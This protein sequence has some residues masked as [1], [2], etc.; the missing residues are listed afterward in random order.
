MKKTSI[1][2]SALAMA[3]LLVT[4][5]GKDSEEATTMRFLRADGETWISDDEQKS[6]DVIEGLSLY[7][8]YGVGTSAHANAWLTLDEATLA[9]MDYSSEIEIEKSDDGKHLEVDVKSGKM[10][11]NVS[12]PLEDDESLDIETSTMTVG[13]RGT[14]GW[15]ESYDDYS[16]VALLEGEVT[17]MSKS[18][19]DSVILGEGYMA[20]LFN[21][22]GFEVEQF[23][24]KD[25]PEFVMDEE[26]ALYMLETLGMN[27]DASADDT[28]TNGN[29]PDSELPYDPKAGLELPEIPD[30]G[31]EREV[32]EVADNDALQAL[33]SGGRDLSNTAIRLGDGE[34]AFDNGL[35]IGAYENLSIIGTGKTR[36]VVNNGGATVLDSYGAKNLLLY[37]LVLGHDISP[38]DECSMG[39]LSFFG[40]ENVSVVGCD[41]YGCG[42]VGI[43]ASSDVT[44]TDSVIRECSYSAVETYSDCTV[45]FIN[46]VIQD[47]DGSYLF[48]GAEGTKFIFDDCIIQGNHSTA[49]FAPASDG[50]EPDATMNNTTEKDNAWQ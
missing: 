10:Y 16:R 30:D 39:V 3:A 36:I 9:K 49:E 35:S 37:G 7:S 12:E 43:E 29:S 23:S 34:Y 24:T 40:C 8:G 44:V 6:L 2:L 46:S 17:L 45:H 15:V 38:M 33:F 26:D 11:F 1:I 47:N 41:I 13:I 42:L 48:V 22:S 18:G 14:A 4:G 19:G 32:I 21:G 50:M 31:I 20:T 5:C 28:G 27:L 25:V